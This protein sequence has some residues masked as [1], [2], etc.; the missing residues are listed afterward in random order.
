M[1]PLLKKDNLVIPYFVTSIMYLLILYLSY[2]EEKLN[3]KKSKISI[4]ANKNSNSFINLIVNFANEYQVVLMGLSYFGN[5]Y[6]LMNVS[7]SNY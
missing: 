2:I 3:N 1:F 6:V 7:N 4:N 5:I